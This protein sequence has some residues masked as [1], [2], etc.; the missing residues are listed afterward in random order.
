MRTTLPGAPLFQAVAILS[1]KVPQTLPRCWSVFLM[2][3][4]AHMTVHHTRVQLMHLPPLPLPPQKNL[5]PAQLQGAP[6]YYTG[7]ATGPNLFT[8]T[9]VS[10]DSRLTYSQ[11]YS[12]L[13]TPTVTQD[14]AHILS[15]SER[16]S[17]PCIVGG[18]QD[19]LPCTASCYL[20]GP[21][22]LA[23]FASARTASRWLQP[24]ALW[25]CR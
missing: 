18:I 14:I 12:L 11:L 19:M 20:L 25:R 16:E 24:L 21:L 2:L 4:T 7:P 9:S 8:N 5:S 3:C 1:T 17:Q 22:P 10:V 23:P 13:S 15:P 6:Y